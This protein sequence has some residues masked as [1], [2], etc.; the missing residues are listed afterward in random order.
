MYTEKLECGLSESDEFFGRPEEL[1]DFALERARVV[2]DLLRDKENYHCPASCNVC[3]YGSIL[4]S[5][6]EFTAIMLYLEE[7]RGQDE[8]EKLFRERVGLLQDAGTLLCPFLKEDAESEHCSIYPVRP[9]ICRVFGTSSSPCEE[10][11]DPSLLEEELFYE[12]YDLLYYGGK[13][14]IALNL[15]E[16]WAVFEAPFAVWRLADGN[17]DSRRYLRSIIEERGESF[18]AVLYDKEES[19]FFSYVRGEKLIINNL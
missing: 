7:N 17:E 2:A 15:D 13:Q 10:I 1:S 19:V 12:A 6:T 16:K 11:G 3:C 14:F 5:Y 4:M 8:I 9:L 18:K